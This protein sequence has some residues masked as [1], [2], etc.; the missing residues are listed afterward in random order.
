[1]NEHDTTFMQTLAIA[2]L[3]LL[4]S[5]LFASPMALTP[6]TFHI[7]E[8]VRRR[9]EELTK[10]LGDGRLLESLLETIELV[11]ETPKEAW[12]Y[13]W[14]RLFEGTVICPINETAYV[15]RDKGMIISDICG[16]Y[17]AFGF[18][19][20]QHSAEKAD[21]LSC[22]LEYVALLLVMMALVL[23]IAIRNSQT[24]SI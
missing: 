14:N 2:D 3:T 7:D 16:F 21:H 12:R 17:N 20:D 22:E 11:R 4:T 6:D 15:R 1:M 8:E 5:K 24:K 10:P 9:L 13:E 19:P 18:E 23:G